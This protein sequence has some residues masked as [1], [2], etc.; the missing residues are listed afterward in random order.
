VA[1]QTG[2]SVRR[3][4]RPLGPATVA[5][6]I[7]ATLLAAPAL[8]YLLPTAAV[9]RHLGQRREALG[10][11]TLEV[12]GT[13][14]AEG[15]S[16]ER[17]AALARGGGAVSVAARVLLKVPGRCRLE[18]VGAT[19]AESPWLSARDGKLAGGGG[20]EA[21]PAA[22]ALVHA[23][24]TLL[25][26]STAGDPSAAYAAALGRRGIALADQSLGRF[27][28]RLAYVI[29]G[30]PRDARPLL[31]VDKDGFQP[32]RLIAPEEGGLLDVR[33]LGW[34]SPTGGDWFPRAVEV[35][36]GSALHLRFTTE[37]ASPNPR[38]PEGLP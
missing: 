27:D 23:L 2:P 38:F 24:C 10:L 12:T 3:R 6:A 34:G 11:V 30:R 31:Y 19:P 28:G 18:V 5:A 7:A 33:L 22:A 13:L 9:L 8:A 37:R 32:L 4:A 25:A 15:A 36:Q 35:S 14:Q 16:A 29:G 1:D 17:L 20:L 21:D 26:S